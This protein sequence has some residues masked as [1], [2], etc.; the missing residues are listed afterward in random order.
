MITYGGTVKIKRELGE[1]IPVSIGTSIAVE[2]ILDPKNNPPKFIWINLRTIFRNLFSDIPKEDKLTVSPSDIASDFS[3]EVHTIAN[4]I[5]ALHGDSVRVV[6]YYSTYD[7]IEKYLPRAK[8]RGPRTKLQ[9]RHHTA[10]REAIKKIFSSEADYLDIREYKV[11][12]D[13]KDSEAWIVTHT[14]VDLLS[15]R[16]FKTLTLLETH[17]GVLKPY[18]TWYTKLRNGKEL[19]RMPFN[20]LT[21]QVFGDNSGLITPQTMALRKQLFEL[22]N[23]NRWSP[24]TT[25]AKIK[26]DLSKLKDKLTGELLKEL[27]NTRVR[28]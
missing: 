27:V 26:S 7:G 24:L 21:L 22:A 15:R 9:I 11:A 1:E 2:T 12:I 13:G 23:E 17:T 5:E 16:Y 19:F 25:R 20:E 6:F 10:E 4:T 14:P 3:D 8:L 18:S 28:R